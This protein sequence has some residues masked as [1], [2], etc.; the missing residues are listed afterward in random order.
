[1]FYFCPQL[2]SLVLKKMVDNLAIVS[3][4]KVE[5]LE[6]TEIS[7]TSLDLFPLSRLAPLQELYLSFNSLKDLTV[8][9]GLA[10]LTV[11]DLSKNS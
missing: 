9:E 6:L 11:L 8:L 4:Q 5:K 3:P 2:L 1:M 10:N 7:L